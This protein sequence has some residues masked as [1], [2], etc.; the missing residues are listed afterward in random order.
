M[1][2]VA[3]HALPDPW[4]SIALVAGAFVLAWLASRLSRRAAEWIVTRYEARHFDG[5]AATSGVIAGLKRRATI[6]SLVQTTLRYAAYG[7][8]VLF[9]MTQLAGFGG[10]GAV[11]GASL[12]VLLVGFA[13]QRF[14]I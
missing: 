3:L 1:A 7:F 5:D 11:A 9:A 13:L 2:D 4:R 10:T 6:V 14:L 8:A 12:L